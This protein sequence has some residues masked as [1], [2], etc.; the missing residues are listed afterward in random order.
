MSQTTPQA[1]Q[2]TPAAVSA[3]VPA[4]ASGGPSLSLRP[5]PIAD[6]KPKSLADFISRINGQ[7]GGFRELSEDKLC[8]ELALKNSVDPHQDVDMSDDDDHEDDGATAEGTGTT[9]DLMQSRVEVLQNI[10]C[11]TLCPSHSLSLDCSFAEGSKLLPLHF[12]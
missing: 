1:P 5:F 4:A 2:A 11:V 9:Q 6:E 10:E 7:P 12:L 8:Q 3:A